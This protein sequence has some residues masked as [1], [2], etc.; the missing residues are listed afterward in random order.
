M[1]VAGL[2]LVS[3]PGSAS[4]KYALYRGGDE[5]SL[6]ELHFE[7]VGKQVVCNLR[8]PRLKKTIGTK[9]ESVK[10]AARVLPALLEKY[11]G[12][13]DDKSVDHIGLRVV[14]PGDF[15]TQ[16]H[17]ITQHVHDQLKAAHEQAPLHIEATL[18]ELKA[19]QS[20]FRGANFYG[21]SDS[22]FHLTKASPAW[23]YGVPMGLASEAGIKR[24]GY[25]G[26]S[27]AAVVLKL[28]AEHQLA[29]KLVVCHLGSGSSVTAL[30]D[31]KSVDTSMG[32][33]P[34]EGLIMAT[35]SGS[36]DISAALAIKQ[37]L[38]LSDDGLEKYLST[39]SGLLGLTG[40]SADLRDLLDRNH[41]GE[42]KAR[43][44]LSIYVYSI[45]KMI[46]QMVAALDGVDAV[47]FTGTIGERSAILRHH[48]MNGLS[49]LGL[50]P[51]A[52]AA[53]PVLVVATDEAGEI[54]R[55][56]WALMKK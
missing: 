24:Y 28:Q 23:Y 32:Y 42:P 35:R 55:R 36:L 39:N 11:A 26:I 10:Q 47:V 19:L 12:V 21:I 38:N 3:N 5:Q 14:A 41:A 7:N 30:R 4:C 45:Q 25:H 34:L 1:A 20:E 22:A 37:H 16:D 33:S 6:L 29:S 18:R 31:G 56:V 49:Y 46:G 44:Q 27:V 51:D 15:F 52:N 48:I 2:I 8:S 13:G 53:K 17:L 54:A 9:L 43:L 50:S 40:L